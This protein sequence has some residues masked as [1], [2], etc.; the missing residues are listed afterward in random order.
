M[1]LENKVS[2]LPVVEEGRVVGILTESDLFR[3]LCQMLG[4]GE[5]GARVV[6]SVDD[7]D[8]LLARI[9]RRL[10]GLAM[11]SLVT[12]HDPKHGRWDVVLRVRGRQNGR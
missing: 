6:M 3:A 5:K 10:S 1:M 12:V 9:R 7:D 4:I 11:R 2:G 8:D